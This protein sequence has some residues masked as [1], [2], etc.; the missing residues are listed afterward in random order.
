MK[1]VGVT[2][3]GFL[4]LRA[5]MSYPQARRILGPRVVEVAETEQS[6]TYRWS[7]QSGEKIT[8]TFVDGALAA[9]VRTGL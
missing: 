5:G 8:A 9:K 4:R 2:M 6:V 1:P 7:G 3:E